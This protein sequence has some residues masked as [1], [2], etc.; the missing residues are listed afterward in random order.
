MGKV[1]VNGIELNCKVFV[2]LVM[3]YLEVFKVI[4]NKVK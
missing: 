4:F 1:K 2:D 3:N